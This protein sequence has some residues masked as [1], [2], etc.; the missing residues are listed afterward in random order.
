H[1]EYVVG[2]NLD[3]RFFDLVNAVSIVPGALGGFRREAIVRA[4]G[5][6]RDT[7]AEDADLTVA[8][9]MYGYQ[10]RT[11]ADARAWTEVPATW[12]AL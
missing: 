7:L 6:P 9:G 11:V 12:R 10:V 8:I 1:L 5:F 3:R 2:I 4:G